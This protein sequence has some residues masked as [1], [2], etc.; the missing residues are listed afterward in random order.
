MPTMQWYKG[1][2]NRICKKV[3]E[4]FPSPVDELWIEILWPVSKAWDN[5]PPSKPGSLLPE[6]TQHLSVVFHWLLF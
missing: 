1:L 2:I 6:S 4:S 3:V 5:S